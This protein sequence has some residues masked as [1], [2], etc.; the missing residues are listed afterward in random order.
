LREKTAIILLG[1]VM[2][3]VGILYL[4]A[5]WVL[6]GSFASL[7]HNYTH[8]NTSR[9]LNAIYDELAGLSTTAEDWAVWDESYSFVQDR[10]LS[11]IEGTL[12]D[13]AFARNRLNLMLFLDTSGALV[14]GKG[15]DLEADKEIPVPDGIWTHL[16]PNGP[17]VSSAL[18]SNSASGLVL[19]PE[20]GLFIA[21][22]PILTSEGGG[23]VKGVLVWGRYLSPA[24]V[25]SLSVKTRLG[26]A[27]VEPHRKDTPADLRVADEA[28]NEGLRGDKTLFVQPLNAKSVAGYAFLKDVYGTPV[29]VLRA[30]MPRSIYAQGRTTLLY[31]LGMVIFVGVVGAVATLLLLSKFV[32]SRLA[33]LNSVV[34]SIA[35][36]NDLS[37]RV[38][39]TGSDEIW[40]L[41]TGIN[42]M[43]ASLQQAQMRQQAEIALKKANEDLDKKVEART[44]DLQAANQKLEAEMAHRQRV[45]AQFRQ[46]QKMEVVGRLAGGV[47]HDFNNILTAILCYCQLALIDLPQGHRAARHLEEVDKAA[48]RAANLTKQL[49][50]FSR[51]Q[52]VQAKE[53]DVNQL[54]MGMH[55]MLRRLIGEDVE[56]VTLPAQD[57]LPVKVDPSHMEQVV[58]NLVVNGRDAMP[59]G[60][61]IT[62]R[63]SIAHDPLPSGQ[64]PGIK[65]G[66]YVMVSVSDT[67][68]GM[69]DQVKAHLFE[70]FFTT[71]GVGQGTGLGLA[72]CYGIV[73]KSGGHIE[74][75]SKEG[76]GTTFRVYLPAVAA[77][78]PVA[79]EATDQ[80]ILRGTETVLV[81]EDE[82]SVRAMI[83]QV[84]REHGYKVMEARDGVEA[85]EVAEASAGEPIHLLLT[86]MVMPRMGGSELAARFRERRPHTRMLF[87]SG[88]TEHLLAQ[89]DGGEPDVQFI[90]KPFMPLD[91][92]RKVREVLDRLQKGTPSQSPV[93]Q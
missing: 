67:G 45:E 64:I 23:P 34:R 16:A 82:P 28:L 77:E 75:D 83:V 71:K 87:T 47:A 12:A 4:G 30:E 13:G 88:Y 3:L 72:T 53:V 57:L 25:D 90:Q 33:H 74:V 36:S 26:L 5:H 2:A 78:S 70:P 27:I 62:I 39:A 8:V 66:P 21:V 56:L 32:L 73:R 51:H 44:A 43:L 54:V 9:A 41:G 59:K 10:N 58:L 68:T 63:T 37:S 29:L 15:Y 17:L 38:V 20:G 48:H 81:V 86:D 49:L 69:S 42:Q 52:P 11:F 6:G 80:P 92:V 7:E 1:T 46:S 24:L 93:K 35:F 40:Q 61:T 89:Q 55:G 22:H 65:P 60:G 31:L 84:L 79:P 76:Q 18:Q 19:L 14:Y 85:L 50:T 91:L